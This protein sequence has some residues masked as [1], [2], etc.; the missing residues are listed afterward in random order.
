MSAPQ[1]T[2]CSQFNQSS[3][4]NAPAKKKA[5]APFAIRFSDEERA[6]LEELAGNQPLGTYIRNQLLGDRAQKRRVTRK[7]NADHKM[8]AEVLASL[9]ETRYASNLNQLAKHA[10]MGTIDVSRDIE[11][12]LND[13]YC[14]IIEMRK[15]LF[16]A[17]GLKFGA[18]DSP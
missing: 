7:P 18:G 10:N 4:A 9:G 1:Q 6:Y 12:E 15:A 14:A 17:L 3:G 16:M 11:Q 8:L 5:P 2:L 13:A